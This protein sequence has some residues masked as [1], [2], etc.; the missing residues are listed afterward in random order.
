MNNIIIELKDIS[1][2]FSENSVFSDLELKI[3]KGRIT[4]IIGPNGCGKTTLFKII[5]GIS[6]R[7]KGEIIKPDNQKFGF[8]MDDFTPYAHLNLV[9]NMIAFSKL[10]AEKVTKKLINGIISE[11]FCDKIRSKQFKKLSAGQKKKAMFAISL[12]NDPEVLVMDEPLNSLDLKERIDLISSIKYMNRNRNKTVIISSHD[13]NSL[14]ELCDNFCFI[15]NGQILHELSKENISSDELTA[16]YLEI[17][18]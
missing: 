4:S 13:L 6:D 2:S 9:Q 1:K 14:Y 10:G 8:M 5:L 15:K 3:E 18:S 17:Y 12:L 16:K 11:T 7:D